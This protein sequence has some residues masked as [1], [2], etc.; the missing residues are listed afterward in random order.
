MAAL[1][2]IDDV[3]AAARRIDGRVRRTPL[4]ASELGPGRSTV[5]L[6]AESLQVGGSF[7]IRGALNAV[8]LLSDE[9]RSRGLVTHSSGNHAQA[10][11]RAARSFGISCTIVMPRNAP[12]VKRAATEALG[13]TVVL[14][15]PHERETA[16]A[17]IQTETGAA[18][19]PP[20]DH[21]A[22]IAGQGTVGLEIAADVSAAGSAVDSAIGPE[23]DTVY[24]P[25]SGGGLVS[26][27]AVAVKAQLP[28][29]RVV[30]VEPE[31]A[32]DLAEGWSRGQRVVWDPAVTAR[33]IADGLRV[34]GVGRLNWSHIRALVDDVVTVTEDEIASAVRRIVLEAKLVCEPS[35][36]VAL[37]G[38]LAAA[39][40]REQGSA[41]VV[42]VSGG[43][44]EPMMLSGLIG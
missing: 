43:N 14:V 13:A 27:I 30:A 36:A 42:V 16:A 25:V 9:E 26:G 3:A 33:T 24:V 28:A 19:I 12:A 35:G 17:A 15:E 20:Y 32:A 18:L 40:R 21:P 37:A 1:V 41:S 39:S 23:I 22:V 5:Y 29:T 7:K 2:T 44:V 10:V 34:A 11:A 4:I 38:C 31:L 6:K 8:S